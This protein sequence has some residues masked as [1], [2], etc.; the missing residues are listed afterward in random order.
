M[1]IKNNMPF[2]AGAEFFYG[3]MDNLNIGAGFTYVF[4][5]ESKVAMDDGIKPKGGTTNIYLAVKPEAKVNSDIFTS[6]YLIGQIGLSMGRVEFDGYS[7]T[8]DTGIY[9]GAGFGTTIKDAFLVELLI[10]SSNGSH[11]ENGYSMDFQYSITSLNVGYK[12]SL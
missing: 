4:D 11:S 7:R 1:G 8:L 9:L 3:L 10:S 5:S 2:M 6:V 12:F